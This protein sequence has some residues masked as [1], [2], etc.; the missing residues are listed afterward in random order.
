VTSTTPAGERDLSELGPG[1]RAVVRAGVAACDAEIRRLE[2]KLRLRR[3][4]GSERA[5]YER[6][7]DGWRETRRELV[8]PSFVSPAESGQPLHESAGGEESLRR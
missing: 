8:S 2:G 4:R 6:E 7:L 1:M 5:H 3:V